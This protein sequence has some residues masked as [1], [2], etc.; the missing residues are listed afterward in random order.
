MGFNLGKIFKHST[1]SI[2]HAFKDAGH[3]I[4]KAVGDVEH[5]IGNTATTIYKDSRSA[6]KYTG[7]HLIKD[8]DNVSS[9]FA[10]AIPM[11]MIGAGAIVVIMVMK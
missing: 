9:S 2:S 1:K 5:T 4:S 8:V 11:L 10:N 7:K 6:I 3:S